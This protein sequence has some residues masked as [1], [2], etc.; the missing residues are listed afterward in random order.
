M[1]EYTNSQIAYII[2]EIVHNQ[3]NRE[4]LKSR[5]IDGICY[6]RLADIYDMSVRQVKNIVY[7][8]EKRLFK[9]IEQE[10]GDEKRL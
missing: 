6:E 4:I 9:R 10:Q 7:R 5:F 1:I 3:R 2:D 8:E